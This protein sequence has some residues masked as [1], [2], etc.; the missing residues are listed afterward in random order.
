LKDRIWQIRHFVYQ[1]FAETTR[2]PRLEETAAR[3]GLALEEAASAYEELHRRHAL[4]LKPGTHEVLMANPFSGVETEFKVRAHG[5]TYFANCAWDTLGIP[6]ALDTDA[7]IESACAWS[8]E[9]IRI[10]VSSMQV[11][12]SDA[13]VHFLI[14]F[15]EWYDN[16]TFT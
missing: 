16:L 2:P 6:A 5:K 11:Q 12:G 1:H 4:Y 9:A 8:G 3:F 15:R 10:R 14:P 13:L 7:E